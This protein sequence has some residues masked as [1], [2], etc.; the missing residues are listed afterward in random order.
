MKE[1]RWLMP[2]AGL[3]AIGLGIVSWDFDIAIKYYPHVQS[4]HV[5]TICFYN[6]INLANHLWY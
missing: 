5:S 1:L 4:P 3:L 2:I 6:V